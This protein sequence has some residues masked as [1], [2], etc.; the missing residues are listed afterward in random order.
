MKRFLLI[1]NSKRPQVQE[2]N[3]PENYPRY[4]EVSVSVGG[5]YGVPCGELNNIVVCDYDTYKTEHKITIDEL[6]VLHGDTLIVATPSGGY[7]AYNKFDERHR[8]WKG[9]CGLMNGLLDIRTQGNYVVG[10]GSI[11]E[12]G[13]YRIVSGSWE[14]ITEMPADTFKNIDLLMTPK[15]IHEYIDC[16][17]Y[18]PLLEEIGFTNIKWVSDYNFTCDQR[19]KGSKC[20]LCDGEHRNNHFFVYKDDMESVWVKNHSSKCTRKKLK[21]QFMF[22][23]DEKELAKTDP[24]FNEEYFGMKRKFEERVCKIEQTLNYIVKEPDDTLTILNLS[25]LRERFLDWRISNEKDR[26]IQFIEVWL[27]DPFK[28]QYQKLDFM[29]NSDNPTIFNTWRG[30]AVEKRSVASDWDK[31]QGDVEPF[32]CLVED[33]TGGETDYFLKWLALLF[34]RPQQKPITAPV[35]FSQQGCGKNT[36][37]DFIGLMMGNDLYYTTD[38]VEQDI[39]GRFTTAFEHRKL[40]MIDEAD[41]RDMAKSKGRL[42]GLITNGT[43]KIERKGIQS[44]DVK[45]LAGMV[46]CSNEEKPVPVEDSDRRFI[47]YQSSQKL[48]GNQEFFDN[49]LNK[50]GVKPENQRA[51]YDYLMGLDISQV[52]WIADRPITQAYKDIRMSCLPWDIKWIEN[53]IVHDFPQEWV[54]NP[55]STQDLCFRFNL[56]TPSGFENKTTQGFGLLLKKLIDNKKLQGF[57]KQEG[58]KSGT[59]WNIDREQVFGWLRKNEYTSESELTD[60]VEFQI[61]DNH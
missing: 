24:E 25:M 38:N 60:P 6:K 28:R 43:T 54:D 29:P 47:I 56:F 2:F 30:Y 53:L 37:M 9:V 4:T 48:R 33:L 39:F 8:N 32:L 21:S 44:I 20:P 55:V 23:E 59:L 18:T 13:T 34:Q 46:F 58:R 27:R 41:S 26:K 16:E 7:H 45:N 57:V 61:S 17:E 42:K 10:A 12:K 15:K 19:G 35:F 1:P 50:W 5:N 52:N 51:V 31:D 40:V 14:D 11:T 49:F 22:H 36:L 3:N